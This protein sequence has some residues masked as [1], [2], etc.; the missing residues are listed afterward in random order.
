MKHGLMVAGILS[1][2]LTGCNE[3]DKPAPVPEMP[4]YF[5]LEATATGE[6]EEF[7]VE[8]RLEFIVEISGEVSRTDE[9]VEYTATMGGEAA[10]QLLRD[11]GSGVAFAADFYWPDR[12]VLDILP[13]RVQIISP[14]FS[15][16]DPSVASRFGHELGF[17]DG[18]IDR[19][20]VI[21]GE[22]LC[23]P[24]DTDRGDINDNVI[25]AEGTWHTREITEERR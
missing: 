20:G 22:W 7:N 9:V 24:L 11:D 18:T 4:T 19:D 5:W 10:R 2:A 23:A 6:S 16:D 3:D 8:C 25:F 17:F 14:K 15:P 12:Q 21:S 1:L 13:N